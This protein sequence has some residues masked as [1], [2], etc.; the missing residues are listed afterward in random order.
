MFIEPAKLED[1]PALVALSER[2]YIEATQM[3]NRQ[4]DH[5]TVAAEVAR[6]IESDDYCVY[7]AR[8]EEVIVGVITGYVTWSRWAE[9]LIAY[10]D[11]WYVVPEERRG[12]CGISLIQSFKNWANRKQVVDIVMN[13]A[14]G[15]MDNK[16]LAKSFGFT[17]L[18]MQVRI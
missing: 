18:G 16:K 11:T 10:E 15:L 8:K 17:P 14:S 6:F 13:V 5:A 2:F 3:H 12:Q 1:I 9:E 7:V 4:F